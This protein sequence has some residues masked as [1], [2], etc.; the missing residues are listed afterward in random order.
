VTVESHYGRGGL[1]DSLDAIAPFAEFHTFGPGATKDLADLASI[2]AGE[3]VLDAGSGI[4]GPLRHLVSEY[5]AKGTGI[6]LTPEFCDAAIALNERAGLDIPIHIGSVLAMPFEDASFDVVW[7]QHVTMNISDK[8]GFYA[9]AHR[10]LRPGGRL[11]FFDVIAG[12][13]QPIHFPVP[14]ADDESI[15]H[16]VDADGMRA[17][18]EGAGFEVREWH[19]RSEAAKGMTGG[20]VVNPVI[21]NVEVKLANHGRNLAEDRCR[22]L[23]AVCIS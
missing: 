21:P 18:V 12:G 3:R 22:L 16:L 9:E 15:S 6:D 13:V 7:T 1:V 4:G 2:V 14:W 11:A 20:G 23:Q 19:D 17:L 8:A 5:G 10:V